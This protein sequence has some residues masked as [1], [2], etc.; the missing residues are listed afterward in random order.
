MSKKTVFLTLI[1]ISSFL[2]VLGNFVILYLFNSGEI[3]LLNMLA[4][5]ALPAC[6][7]II[8]ASVVL[9]ANARLFSSPDFKSE[10]K[11]LKKVLEK[12]GGVP[13]K[14][15]ALIVIL[16]AAFLFPVIF[17]TGESLG[18]AAELRIFIYGACLA[19]GMAVGTFVYNLGEGIV[20]H[21]IMDQNITVYPRDLREDRQSLKACVIPVVMCIFSV[22]LTFSFVVLSLSKA[23]V[24]VTTTRHGGWNIIIAVLG[25]FFIYLGVLSVY[26]KKNAS[27]LYKSIIVQ[28][29]NLSSGKK[30]LKRRINIISVDELGSIA[31]MMNSFCD[32]IA[33]GM[34]EIK[35]G[36]Q[37]LSD[38]SRQLHDNAQG[39]NA[40]IGLISDAIV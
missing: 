14:S 7:Y 5:F 18:L 37:D 28:M 31:G 34:S 2:T 11:K 22:V 1:V 4:R 17:V 20:M 27:T 3:P 15:I 38:S 30:D 32:N 8:A 29:E 12:I 10:G 35:T 19:V 21:T 9:G 16:Q 26:I 33:M 13:I 36:Q 39:M 23:G 25:S 6:G 24:D 40:A